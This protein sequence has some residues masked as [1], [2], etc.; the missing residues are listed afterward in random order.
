M[1][2][3][4]IRGLVVSPR[5]RM[6]GRPGEGMAPF[7][8]DQARGP[9]HPQ[10][11][12]VRAGKGLVGDRYF[13]TRFAYAAVTFL[14]A[15]KVARLQDEIVGEGLFEPPNLPFDPLAAR[16]NVV[17]TGLDVDALVRTRFT[18]DAGHGPIRFRSITPANP[19]AW[20]NHVF[21]AGAHRALRGHAGI[22]C[23]PL[24]DGWLSIGPA[25]LLDVVE[26]PHDEMRR[27]VSTAPIS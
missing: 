16:R 24:D 27:R 8:Q 26:I 22:R 17:T 1:T 3:F 10:T 9:E 14:A 25:R 5:R 19:C 4:E 12:E 15:E 20:M 11:V 18:I 21:A 13:N 2:D 6:D 7:A 23:E